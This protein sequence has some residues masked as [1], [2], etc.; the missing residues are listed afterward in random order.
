MKKVTLRTRR[1]ITIVLLFALVTVLSI[2]Y[3]VTVRASVQGH[4][5]LTAT[6]N[7]ESGIMW[8][9]CVVKAGSTYMMWYSGETAD[10]LTDR[11]G[12]ATSPDGVAWTKY[13]QNPIMSGT[14]G[15][16]DE[17]SVN[18]EWVIYES[19]QYKMWYGGQTIVNGNPTSYQIGYATSS[20][21][22]HWTKYADNPVLAPGP[23]GTWDDLYV[24]LPTVIRN[25]SSYIMYYRGSSTKTTVTSLKVESSLGMATSSDGVHWK[26]SGSPLT[27]ARSSSGWDTYQ[28]VSDVLVVGGRYLLG[29][30]GS[31]T[32]FPAPKGPVPKVKIGFAS[33]LDGMSWT[34]DSNNPAIVGGSGTWDSGGVNYPMVLPVGDNLYV[35]YAAYASGQYEK[36]I[37]LAVLPAAQLPVPEYGSPVLIIVAVMLLTVF[38][39]RR[40]RF[41]PCS[42]YHVRLLSN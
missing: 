4:L 42:G 26:K 11:I 28:R 5:L 40:K 20:D 12:L 22:I 33:S 10:Y 38:V 31:P 9:P 17:G 13:S 41:Q 32:P 29:Y 34:P 18:D 27:L 6:D 39:T 8:R 24:H 3:A 21:G 30:A 16:W 25:G 2:S 23:S 35:Y 36:A 19:G 7:W 15:Q 1:L 37:G 14:P